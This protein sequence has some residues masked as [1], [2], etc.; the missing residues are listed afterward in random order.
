MSETKEA[1]KAAKA[2]KKAAKKAKKGSGKNP[3]RTILAVL[4][5]IAVIGE[6]YIGLTIKGELAD[7][8]KAMVA[9]ANTEESNEVNLTLEPNTYGGYKIETLADVAKVYNDAYNKTKAKTAQYKDADGNTQ[10]FYAFLGEE[11]LTLK[12]GSLLVDGSS[13]KIVDGLVPTILG[14]AFQPNVNGLPP[15]ANRNPDEDK[16]D[17][18]ASL[19]ESRVVES[20][21]QSASAVENADGTVTLTIAPVTTEMSSKGMDPQGHFFNTLGKLDSVVAGI[22]VVSFPEGDVSQYVKATYEGGTVVVTIDPAT[23]EFTSAEYH[24]V[25]NVNVEH[26]SITAL[27]DKSASLTLLYDNK[28]P[29]SDAYLMERRQ[30]VRL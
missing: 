26:A 13:N 16:D 1:K 30:L 6:L 12:E 21:I 4:L 8:N 28:F 25:V 11:N 19:K 22:S 24:M 7:I 23:G 17:T 18:G 5:V 14:S 3:F 29:A 9:N 15:Q 20:D 2:E 10:T 27:K